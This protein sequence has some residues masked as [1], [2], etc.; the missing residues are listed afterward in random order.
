MVY[1]MPGSK[2]QT[3]LESENVANSHKHFYEIK[4]YFKARFMYNWL[5]LITHFNPSFYPTFSYK[6]NIHFISFNCTLLSLFIWN[7]YECTAILHI[8]KRKRHFTQL[9]NFLLNEINTRAKRIITTEKHQ[10]AIFKN[11]LM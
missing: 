4:T 2:F 10:S 11:R 3:W 1:M 8:L 6:N 9:S 5:F 7:I